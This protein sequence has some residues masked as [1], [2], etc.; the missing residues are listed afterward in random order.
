MTSPI[1]ADTIPIS[2]PYAK[3]LQVLTGKTKLATT[4]TNT[5]KPQPIRKGM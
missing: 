2:P 3:N 1:I 5:S 4:I